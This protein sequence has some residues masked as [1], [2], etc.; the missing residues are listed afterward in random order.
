MFFII[1]GFVVEGALLAAIIW[2]WRHE[3]QVIDFEKKV[4][5]LAKEK[6]FNSRVKT[7]KRNL[8]ENS[9]QKSLAAYVNSPIPSVAR[10]GEGHV[11][12]VVGD[13]NNL[14]KATP[15][16]WLSYQYPFNWRGLNV[17]PYE[18][19]YFIVTKA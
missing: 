19:G 1:F 8:I 14:P 17:Q 7:A 13:F 18:N 15:R 6:F 9:R 4:F 16:E 10:Y 5:A 11:L 12:D 2:V 3:T